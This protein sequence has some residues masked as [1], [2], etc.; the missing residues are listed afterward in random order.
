MPNFLDEYLVKLG[1][2]VDAAGFARFHQALRESASAVDANAVNM[3]KSIFKAQTEIVGGFAAIGSAALGLVD[4][5]AM[6]D[7]EFRLFALHMYMSKDAAR[8]LKVAMDALGQ[9]LEN[10]AW[11]PELRARTRQLLEDQRAMAPT[12][13][14]NDQMRKIRD[15]R[16]EFTRM[17]VELQYLGMHVVQDFFK[18]LGLGPDDLLVKL[19]SFNDWVTKHLPEISHWVVTNFLPVWRDVKMIVGDVVDVLRDFA[20]LFDNIIAL[21]SGDSTLKG[22]ADFDKFARSVEKV[23][24]WLAMVT[25]FLLQIEGIITGVIGGGAAGGVIGS[26]IGGIAGIPAGPAGIA[27]GIL[28]GGAT[29]TA[30]GATVGGVGGG[31]FDLLRHLG[32][33]PWSTEAAAPTGG[34]ATLDQLMDAVRGTESGRLGMSALSPK[35]AIGT[36]Q[37]MPGTA[38]AL[39]VNPYD[40]ADN[41]R[42]AYMLMQQLLEHYHGNVAEALG[43]YNWNPAGM[44]K[45]LAGKATLPSETRNYIGNAL[46][47]A[48]GSGDVQVG[49]VVIHINQP[50]ASPLQIQQAVTKGLEEAANKRVQRNLAQ[51]NDLGWSY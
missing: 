42:G 22:V 7:Q 5:V 10:L 28:A 4:K 16:F 45:F 38:R 24:H 33:G 32:V 13:D 2:T 9:P 21:L 46:G 27:G 41:K 50:N 44:D 15:I 40:A 8:G 49:S 29:G 43:A 3:A 30:I 11:D 23:V 12:G 37:L 14:F 1:T 35:G 20:T 51:F 34:I 17:E 18:A 39:G 6:G 31:V 25:H 26:I 47:R 19:R 48:G 36:Y